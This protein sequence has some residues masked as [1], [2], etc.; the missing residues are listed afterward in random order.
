[1]TGLANRVLLMDRLNHALRRIERHP[2]RIVVLFI[3][4]DGFK[5]VIDSY[6]H[7]AGDRLLVEATER[8]TSLTRADDTVAR[9]GGDEFVVLCEDMDSRSDTDWIAGQVVEALR[10]PY[11]V[12]GVELFVTA[13]VGVVVCNDP[14]MAA[15]NLIRDADAAMYQAKESGRNSYQFFDADLRWQA[16]DR[17]KMEADLLC[18]LE[19]GEFRL[20]Y[21]PIFS[22]SD[23]QLVGSEALIRW[24]HPTRGCVPPGEFI[25]AAEARGLIVPIGAWVLNEA[26]RQLAV[27]SAE[28]DPAKP[29]LVVSVN[30]AA[31]QLRAGNFTAVVKEAVA[32][33]GIA[34]EQ[35]CLEIT[36]TVLL[37]E[38]TCA[39]GVLTEL[40]TMGVHIA[41]DDFG[42]GFSSLAHLLNLPVNTVKID[43]S[44]VSQMADNNR[45]REIVAAV[46]AMVH[47]LGMRVVGEGIETVEQ[48]QGLRELQCDHGQGFLLARPMRPE[49]LSRLLK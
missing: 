13:S 10:E 32:T 47:V 34:P 18:A 20:E 25:G 31:R 42:T 3:D 36:E 4:L 12:D 39:E 35:L 45:G 5:G 21:Q 23:E 15:E 40:A 28:R 24:D 22:L 48:L 26:C 1:V 49:A 17:Y 30:V 7:G 19:R 11:S 44:F 27:W 43:R 46:T 8:L 33:H 16:A 37:E 38:A 29:P 6:G 9:F 2:G 41:L 14:T